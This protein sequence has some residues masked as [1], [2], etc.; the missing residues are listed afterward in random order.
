MFSKSH[1]EMIHDLQI[2]FQILKLAAL[3]PTELGFI[4]SC[5]FPPRSQ[6]LVW[7]PILQ[8]PRVRAD[9]FSK[10]HTEE[11]QHLQR[12][13]EIAKLAALVTTKLG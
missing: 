3:L 5:L 2:R 1:K 4:K 12:R 11:I 13:F 8:E 6:I 10:S 9:M 7:L